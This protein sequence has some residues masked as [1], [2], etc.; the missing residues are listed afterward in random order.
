MSFSK[1]AAFGFADAL[2]FLV[3]GSAIKAYVVDNG[4]SNTLRDRAAQWQREITAWEKKP[5]V[6]QHALH[7][8][9]LISKHNVAREWVNMSTFDRF[10]RIP[11]IGLCMKN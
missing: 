10:V 5:Y 9:N 4:V 11:P 6:E 1:E 8:V 2:G 3:L 7:A